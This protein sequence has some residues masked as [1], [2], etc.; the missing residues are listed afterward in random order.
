MKKIL[1][2]IIIIFVFVALFP[3][4]V[5]AD[6]I[7]YFS[8][9]HTKR[10]VTLDNNKTLVIYVPK[11]KTYKNILVHFHGFGDNTLNTYSVEAMETAINEHNYSNTVVFFPVDGICNDVESATVIN[12]TVKLVYDQYNKFLND[13]HIKNYNLSVSQVSGTSDAANAFI[14]LIDNKKIN[15]FLFDSFMPNSNYSNESLKKVNNLIMLSAITDGNYLGSAQAIGKRF[16]EINQNGLVV[17]YADSTQ[18]HKDADDK[19]L[20]FLY[21]DFVKNKKLGDDYSS[22][23]LKLQENTG[24]SNFDTGSNTGT[25]TPSEEDTPIYGGGKDTGTVTIEDSEPRLEY[26]SICD[27]DGFITASKIAGIVILVAKWLAPLILIIYGMIDFGK[28][29]VSNDDKALN[30]ATA[31]FIKRMVI[32]IIIPF[33][34]GLLFYLINYLVGDDEVKNFV[35]STEVNDEQQKTSFAKCTLC[36]NDPF[37]KECIIDNNQNSEKE[38]E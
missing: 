15:L 26:G 7:I 20:D 14:N 30:N 18:L 17:H 35:N 24:T 5:F 8:S 29:I 23:K 11:N 25:S 21:P 6:Q 1:K 37:N 33:I 10:I 3:A 27:S 32:A 31:T 19:G 4:T 9:T 36:L 2:F 38:G 12:N 34:P 13:N 22:E 28:V 16:K